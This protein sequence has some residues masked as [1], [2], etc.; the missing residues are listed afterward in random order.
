MGKILSLSS[1][2]GLL[3]I[4]LIISGRHAGVIIC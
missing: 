2:E 4:Y 3:V 1:L